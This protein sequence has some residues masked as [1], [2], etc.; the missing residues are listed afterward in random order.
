MPTSVPT[1]TAPAARRLPS[2]TVTQLADLLRSRRGAQFVGFTALTR[3][4]GRL[5]P[6]GPLQKLVRV[7]ATVGAFYDRALRKATGEQAQEDRAWGEQQESCLVEKTD[8]RTGERQFYLPTQN[9]R[10][11]KPVYLVAAPDGK[12]A[13]I[14]AESAKLYLRERPARAVE[15]RDYRL[16]SLVAIS[17]GGRRYRVRTT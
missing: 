3:P 4:E 1:S 12:L 17:F 2:I 7:N 9:P 6:L 15:K 13:P 10:Q 11:G 16:D 8:P 5:T 14:P